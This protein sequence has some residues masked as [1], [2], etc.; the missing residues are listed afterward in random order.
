MVIHPAALKEG[1]DPL[2]PGQ[3]ALVLIAQHQLTKA[4]R[5]V[6][7]ARTVGGAPFFTG[8][9]RCILC[10]LQIMKA[11]TN[12]FRIAFQD[13]HHVRLHQAPA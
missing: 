2:V 10:F 5:A 9:P 4:N 3:E 8:A 13:S 12:G 6:R 1:L 11:W 7:L